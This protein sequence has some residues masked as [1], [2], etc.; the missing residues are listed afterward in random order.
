MILLVTGTCG[1]PWPHLALLLIL[2]LG[3][4]AQSVAALVSLLVLVLVTALYARG[5][6]LVVRLDEHGHVGMA[7]IRHGDVI[8]GLQVGGVRVR[9][10]FSDV[11]PG[12][13]AGGVRVRISDVI[14]GLKVGERRLQLRRLVLA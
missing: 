3:S 14:A 4:R 5:L 9:V 13:K 10:R 7:I 6:R 2:M 8:P 11:I 1:A 12:L